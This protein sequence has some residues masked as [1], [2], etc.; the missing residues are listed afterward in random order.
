MLCVKS[1]TVLVSSP[2]LIRRVYRFQYNARDTESDPRWGW[3]W[4]WDW[5]YHCAG[6]VAANTGQPPDD[7]ILCMRY[8]AVP[9]L[10]VSHLP[11]S[12]LP[13]SRCSWWGLVLVESCL[14]QWVTLRAAILIQG[15]VEVWFTDCSYMVCTHLDQQIG[16]HSS[17]QYGNWMKRFLKIIVW[18]MLLPDF[19]FIH[20]KNICMCDSSCCCLCPVGSGCPWDHEKHPRLCGT[21]LL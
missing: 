1:T 19:K 14:A 10:P 20:L 13:V 3:F 18:L 4:V 16:M 17:I 5:D 12:H 6:C 8:I 7:C 21:L 11:V 15:G 9:H 2:D